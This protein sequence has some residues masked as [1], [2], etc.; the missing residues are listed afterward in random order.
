[1]PFQKFNK[2]EE[3]IG[4]EIQKLL[5]MEVISE[6]KHKERQFIS[7]VFTRPKKDGEYRM[8]LNLKELNKYITYHH[9]KVDTFETALNLVTPNCFMASIDLR[10]AYY[11]ISIANSHRRYLRLMWK[12]KIYEY[13]CLPSGAACAPRFFTKLLKPVY[14][15]FRQLGHKNSGYIHDTL[16]LADTK[17]ECESNVRD[18]VSAMT[19]VGFLI[20]ENKSVFEPTVDIGFLGNRINSEKNDC[21]FAK[22]Q[23]RH[24]CL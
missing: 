5:N 7:P 6:V 3:I 14:A 20:H 2:E 10:L 18:T 1:M 23:T 11:C 22:R 8:S 12:D 9:F 21:I 19:D 16:L 17:K 24:H 4:K 15:K 13:S